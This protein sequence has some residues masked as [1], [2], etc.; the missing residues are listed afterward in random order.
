MQVLPVVC[1]RIGEAHCIMQRTLKTSGVLVL[2]V[3]SSNTL[4]VLLFGPVRMTN[5]EL[6]RAFH[7]INQVGE[8]LG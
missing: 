6:S 1:R 7:C 2:L 5:D 3:E 4:S 8:L